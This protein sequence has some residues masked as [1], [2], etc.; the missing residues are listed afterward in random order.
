M[1][2]DPPWNRRSDRR[3]VSLEYPGAHGL[4]SGSGEMARGFVNDCA[5]RPCHAPALYRRGVECSQVDADEPVVCDFRQPDGARGRGR[6]P[7]LLI[8]LLCY[9]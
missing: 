4:P 8:Y 5:C 3:H 6:Q 9:L 7:P 1:D 2:M